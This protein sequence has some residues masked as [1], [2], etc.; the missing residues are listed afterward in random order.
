MSTYNLLPVE[1]NKLNT[2]LSPKAN[3]ILLRAWGG[4]LETLD[5]NHNHHPET[6]G[7]TQQ[8]VPYHTLKNNNNLEDDDDG[9]LGIQ[10]DA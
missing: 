3:K 7:S 4:I 1:H 8:F 9:R 6:Y 5:Q 10:A 2:L